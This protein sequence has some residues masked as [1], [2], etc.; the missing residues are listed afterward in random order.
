[1]KPELESTTQFLVRIYKE[2]S[3]GGKSQGFDRPSDLRATLASLVDIDQEEVI[4]ND[5]H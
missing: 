1:M 4:Y 5:R 2:T 3:F